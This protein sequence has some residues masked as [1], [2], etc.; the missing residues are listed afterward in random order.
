MHDV[1][2]IGGG[3]NGLTCA[4]Y[5]AREG[6][7][8]LVLEAN[9]RV[10]GF[11]VTEDIPGA[12]GFRGN[13]YAIEFP[14]VDRKPSVVE[15]LGLAR[16]GLRFTAP[17]PNNT[18]VGPE[19]THFSNYHSLDRTCD[20]IARL[21]KK[22]AAA[23]RR[24]MTSLTSLLDVGLP[25]LSDHPT[26]PSPATLAEIA[27]HAAKQRKHLLPA[28]RILLQTPMEIIDEFESEEVR[29]WLAM[30]VTTGSFRPLDE[31]ANTSILV[32]FAYNH[33]YPIRRPV[34]GAGAFTQAL[35]DCLRSYGGELR[36]SAPVAQVLVSGGRTTGVVLAS[37]E[38]IRAT[39]VVAAIDPTSLFTKLIEPSAL[40]GPLH[41]EVDR[42]LVLSSGV[43]HLNGNIAV[44]RRPTFPNHS[45]GDDALAGLSF[46]PS[47]DYVNR[48]MDSLK[49][50]EL[51]EELPFYIAIPSILDRSLVPPG[52]DGENIWL[53]VGAVPLELVNGQHWAQ[54]KQGVFDHIVDMLE[55]YS[56]GF[57][58]SI[59]SAKINGPDDFNSEWVHKGSSRAVDLIP[60][61]IG[62]W[63]PS[64]SFSGYA[65]PEIDG[66]W[67]SGHGTHP[68]SGTNGWPGR[69]TARTMLKQE[70]GIRRVL[71]R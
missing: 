70:Y 32:Y 26:R 29:A 7:R 61:Q 33:K 21:S 4:A 16:F 56:P 35:V 54:A 49:R 53:W 39:Q 38:E 11:V 64:P 2:I 19:G 13:T 6:K 27:R 58:S 17:D 69:L 59:I 9:P 48:M 43:S 62:P 57:R 1:V 20:S 45:F 55:E 28:A 31:I 34:G 24:L 40:S 14:F 68:M 22:D 10:G 23:Y 41:D 37:G 52:S 36:T 47:V 25:Y 15:E 44:S 71:R 63:R 12:P 67:R 46:A 50:G 65:T 66:L 51:A 3:H 42:M 18:Y 5:L 60:S 8:V 30:N